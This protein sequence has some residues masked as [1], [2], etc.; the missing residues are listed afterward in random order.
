MIAHP[1]GPPAV[2][3]PTTAWQAGWMLAAYAAGQDAED[4]LSGLVVGDIEDA[5]PPRPDWVPVRVR[6]AALNHHDVWSL[7]GVGLAAE[8]LPMVL[9][10]DAAGLDPDGRE[11]IVHAVVPD[12]GWRGDA[13][14]DPARTL[15]SAK[16]PRTLAQTAWVPPR[17][18]VPNPS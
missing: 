18:L 8:Q 1:R 5:G 6:A 12:P 11:V 15:I 2:R 4:P 14:L 3:R 16:Y 7:R 9:G 10:C 17:D 13:T